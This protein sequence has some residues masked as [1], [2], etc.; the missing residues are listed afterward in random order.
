[1][2]FA[3]A[4][5]IGLCVV[6]AVSITAS[7][8]TPVPSV[9][10][11]FGVDTTVTPV[12]EIVRLTRDYLSRPDSS[13]RTR[14]LW[15]SSSNED[16]QHGDLAVSAYQGF[17]ATILGVSGTGA[18]DSVFV[19]KVLHANSDS[20]RKRISAVA[21]QRL[22]AIRAPR[23]RYGWQFSS[24]VTRETRS[25]ERR[26]V[27]GINF[28]YEPGQTPSLAKARRAA[29][30]VDSV[31]VFLQVTPPK[32]LNA[33]VTE[34][35]DHSWRVLGL[36]FFPDGSG[37]G[38]GV[39]GR[40]LG[41]KGILLL[42]DPSVGEAYLHEFVHAVLDGKLLGHTGVFGEGIAEWLGGHHQYSYREMV[43]MLRSYQASHASVSLVSVLNGDAPGGED[44]TSALYAS[45]GLI[46]ESIYR[47]DGLD[48]VRRFADFRGSPEDVVA[49]LPR[50]VS[51]WDTRGADAWW[52]AEAERVLQLR[53]TS[54]RRRGEN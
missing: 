47:R 23:S 34:S 29:R 5:S 22:Y 41:G 18:G 50:F 33:Y 36:D 54:H 9:T 25:W 24:P 7:S 38:T 28:I 21:L 4:I 26:R 44:A 14:G 39:G 30:F 20:S 16:R 43:A 17:R 52:R 13:A 6:G 11:S 19:V 48:G 35:T 2:K 46:I 10:L 49:A 8:Q 1:V 12:G 51:N 31:S 3:R 15:S 32:N 53:P 42:G 40:Y 45:S 37:P 27:G